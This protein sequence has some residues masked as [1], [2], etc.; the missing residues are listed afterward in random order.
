MANHKWVWGEDP[1][2]GKFAPNIRRGLRKIIRSQN[3]RTGLF[4]G[5]TYDFGFAMLVLA[6]AYGVVDERMLWEGVED[7]SA[8]KTRTIG[9]AL[10]LAVGAAIIPEKKKRLVHGSWYSTGIARSSIATLVLRMAKRTELSA[11]TAARKH[12]TENLDSEYETHI[13]YGRYYMAQALFQSD[14]DSWVKWNRILIRR[15]QN[16]RN[17]DGSVGSSTY[18]KSYTTGISLLALALNYRLLPVYER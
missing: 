16:E 12:I 11:Y 9:K 6:E 1:N 2:F 4:K 10:E 8:K 5:N 13:Y 14:Y 15:V 17:D 7:K 3:P 18:G